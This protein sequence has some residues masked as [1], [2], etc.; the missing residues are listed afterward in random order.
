MNRTATWMVMGLVMAALASA[1]GD[2]DD[3]AKPDASTPKNKQDASTGNEHKDASMSSESDASTSGSSDASS[4]SDAASADAGGTSGMCTGTCECNKGEVCDYECGADCNVGCLGGQCTADCAKGGCTLDADVGGSATYTCA[5]GGCHMD[6]DV[7]SNCALDCSGGGCDVTCDQDS[8]CTVS[9][10]KGDP[11]TVTCENGGRG[12]CEGDN[13]MATNCDTVCEPDPTYK[14]AIDPKDFTTVIDN[15]LQPWPIGAVFHSEGGGEV[16][17]VTV[18]DTKKKINGVNVV[19]VHDEVHDEQGTLTEDT[20]DYYAQDSK[21]NVWYFGEDTTEYVGTT[22][23][24]AG[25]WLYGKD[26]ALPGIVMEAMPK[27]GDKYRQEYYAC[28]AEDMGEVVEVGVSLKGTPTGDYKDCVTTRDYS[29]LEPSAN[30]LKT[31]CPGAGVV[32][33]VDLAL[34]GEVTEELKSLKLP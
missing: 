33:V 6:C 10:G 27:K 7:G 17:T 29:P 31:Y 15:P 22:K 11:C 1:C 14:P 32:K 2:D 23:S 20:L 4:S 18:T 9:C 26:G 8:T 28:E 13:C 24:T 30:E 16:I 19:V 5:G 34:G 21:G 3:S 12:I 25:S